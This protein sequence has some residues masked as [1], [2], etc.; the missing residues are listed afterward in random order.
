MMVEQG[1]PDRSSIS[2]VDIY[3][4]NQNLI[5]VVAVPPNIDDNFLSRQL[6]C[7]HLDSGNEKWMLGRSHY[8]KSEFP[9]L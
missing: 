5:A 1:R 9:F 3:R 6:N 4:N 8:V 2:E 7:A